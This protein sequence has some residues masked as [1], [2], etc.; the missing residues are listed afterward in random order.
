MPAP[1]AQQNIL[2]VPLKIVGSTHFGR[3]NKI[4]IEQT[5]NMIISDDFLVDYSGYKNV[6]DVVPASLGRG[7]Y[8]S[9]NGDF[10][11]A[12]WNSTV[13]RINSTITGVLSA[14]FIGNLVT[15]E[16]DVF[17][18]EN[19][20]Q[21][22]AITDYVN[23]YVYDWS[24]PGAMVAVATSPP[25]APFTPGY[26]SFQNQRLIVAGVDTQAWYISSPADANIWTGTNTYI[27][28]L[29]TKPDT[30]QAVVPM[31]G[32]GNNILVFG[33]TVIE[34]YQYTGAVLF[35]YQAA[36]SFN[37]DYGCLNATS[38]A[39]LD[40]YVVWLGANEQG[41]TTLMY[42]T[43][44]Q[45]KS[46]ST[47]GI[48]FKFSQLSDPSNC[49][50]FL[51]RQ[52]GHLIYQFTFPDEQDNLS[53]CYDFN[54]EK[55]FTVTDENLN[56]HIAR[57]VVFYNDTYYF[58]S[59]NGGNL[60]NF[61]TQYS[62]FQYSATNIQQMPRIRI[63]PPIRLPSQRMFIGK[64][65]GFTIE[66]G[67]PNQITTYQ[68]TTPSD[69]GSDIAT[70]NLFDISTEAGLML[71]TEAGVMPVVT[72]TYTYTSEAVDLS[73]SRDG[74]ESFGSSWRLPMNHTGY[75]KSRFI[76]QRLGQANDAT[77]QLKFVGFGRF[78]A[79]DGIVEIYT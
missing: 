15:S 32:G 22:I 42:Y 36:S 52:D 55:F 8:T 3:Y 25:A 64:S 75:R 35:P 56:Y 46:I 76:Y 12:V 50:G 20:N 71:E 66:N 1:L 14:V 62:N 38:I 5:F 47:D 49:T 63:C 54:T 72:N 16:G 78:V 79:T 69:M 61:S 17:I 6:L 18:S 10:I 45:V 51:F 73:I 26:I 58:V 13:Y 44:H 39:A 24:M 60:Y 31:P 4:S 65:L 29:Q 41:G 19:N 67:Q 23:I 48:D 2:E 43:G 59:L 33:N 40:T 37:V 57:N 9:V 7:I 34:S 70:E 30:V 77:Y 68:Y 53:Y 28:L 27:G 74:G 21:Q 11:I